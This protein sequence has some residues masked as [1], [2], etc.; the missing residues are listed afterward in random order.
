MAE[1][2]SPFVKANKAWFIRKVISDYFRA[3]NMFDDM[4]REATNGRELSFEKMKKLSDILYNTKENLYL[5]FRRIV[6]PDKKTFEK[7][8][9][10]IPNQNEMDFMNNIGLLFHKAMVGRELKYVL[11]HYA[12]NS[13]DYLDTKSSLDMY[14]ERMNELFTAGTKLAKTVLIENSNYIEVLSY[15]VENDKYIEE[16]I[17]EN[18]KSLLELIEGKNNLDNAYLKVGEYCIESGWYDRARKSLGEAV[19]IN[20]DNY[21]AK[22]LLKQ[23]I[24]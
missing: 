18:V 6:D 11:D 5:I 9:K 19:R 7:A 20:P 23:K 13:N 4:A 1:K 2:T 3:K 22:E 14:W 15:I 10:A 12:I 17:G 21:K 8:L 24:I 16:A